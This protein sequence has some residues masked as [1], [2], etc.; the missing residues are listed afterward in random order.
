[1]QAN[2][3]ILQ[4]LNGYFTQNQGKNKNKY[5][6]VELYTLVN[7]LLKGVD[8]LPVISVVSALSNTI[9]DPTTGNTQEDQTYNIRCVSSFYCANLPTA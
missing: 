4:K 6:F 9:S 8:M 3:E 1:M 5:S 7:H 2:H